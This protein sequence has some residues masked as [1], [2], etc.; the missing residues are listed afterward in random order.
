MEIANL[1]LYVSY[2]VWAIIPFRQFKGAFFYYFLLLA[3]EDPLARVLIKNFH[4]VQIK[5]HL[6]FSVFIMVA[7]IKQKQFPRY[8]KYLIPFAVLYISGILF[9][10][11]SNEAYGNN[12]RLI[13]A[14]FHV[15]LFVIFLKYLVV[16]I[17]KEMVFNL[18]LL[19]L[20]LYEGLI[21]FK[22][23][24]YGLGIQGGILFFYL[25]GIFQIFIG[26][27]FIAV[28]GDN[29]KLF[30]KLQDPRGQLAE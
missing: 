7:I 9:V 21:V 24:L 18:F 10:D 14:M 29:P 8:I 3:I 20:V 1:V 5:T 26:L 4:F 6:L 25:T 12:L 2:I 11:A 17:K 27:F 15:I 30:I 23:I 13:L 22:F 16:Q 19:V 28:R